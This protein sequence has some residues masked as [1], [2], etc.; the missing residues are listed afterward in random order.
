MLVVVMADNN[1]L[2]WANKKLALDPASLK[3]KQVQVEEESLNNTMS[4]IKSG[5]STKKTRKSAMKPSATNK[6]K[7]AMKS[8]KDSPMIAS[9]ATSISQLTEQ[10]NKIKQT[11]KMF[12]ACFD[13]LAEQMAA[14]LAATQPQNNSQRHAGGHTSGSGCPT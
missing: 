14:L 7:Q 9:Q 2:Y 4:T 6:G 1:N 12:I 3:Q 13:Q 11:N 5:L 10:V 8:Q